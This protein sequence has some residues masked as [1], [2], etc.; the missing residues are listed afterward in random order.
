MAPDHDER[1][2]DAKKILNHGLLF[3]LQ[4]VGFANVKMHGERLKT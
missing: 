1:A 2:K 3:G 4:A